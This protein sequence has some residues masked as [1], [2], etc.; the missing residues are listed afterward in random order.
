MGKK[1]SDVK[2]VL[3]EML[4][5]LK[6]DILEAVDQKLAVVKSEPAP[7]PVAEESVDQSAP[8]AGFDSSKPR[9]T[10]RKI[11][12]TGVRL[13]PEGLPLEA[14]PAPDGRL[15]GEVCGT[16][17]LR[18]MEN[19]DN[20]TPGD[21]RCTHKVCPTCGSDKFEELVEWKQHGDNSPNIT[22]KRTR[23]S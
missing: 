19:V 21:L 14:H 12:C 13:S 4:G 3:K 7:E 17:Y 23:A 15:S 22:I 20:P 10:R 11:R 9:A 16:V 1:E 8:V 6:A 5:E 2:D 18:L